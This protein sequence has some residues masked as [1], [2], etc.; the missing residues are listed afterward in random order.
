MS[1]ALNFAEIDEQRVEFLPARTV[2]TVLGN[3]TGGGSGDDGGT[4]GNGGHGNTGGQG[5][6]GQGVGGQ[7][8]GGPGGVAHPVIGG[9]ETHGLI[10]PQ[11][12]L[13]IAVGGLGG[14]GIGG[15]GAGG[16]G[17]GGDVTANGGE[18]GRGGEDFNLY[19][20]E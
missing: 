14:I 3:I 19:N 18:G 5:V 1:N 20:F 16:T 4:A 8:V 17:M 11:I 2:M 15:V 13:A 6:G 9:N 12:N 10:A 7:G